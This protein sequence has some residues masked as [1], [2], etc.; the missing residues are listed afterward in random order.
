MDLSSSPRQYLKLL[1][2]GTVIYAQAVTA[3]HRTLQILMHSQC[4]GF[5]TQHSIDRAS[6]HKHTCILQAPTCQSGSARRLK[7]SPRWEPGK[8][9]RMINCSNDS[10]AA[11][12]LL[13]LHFMYGRQHGGFCLGPPVCR[14][15]SVTLCSSCAQEAVTA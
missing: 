1:L 13:S 7:K 6:R 8:T 9:P 5:S 3:C 4:G 14:C 15:A 12:N 11:S 10:C 2:Q